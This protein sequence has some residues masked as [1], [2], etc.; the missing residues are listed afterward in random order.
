VRRRVDGDAQAGGCTGRRP[1]ARPLQGCL[2][3]PAGWRSVLPGLGRLAGRPRRLLLV[4]LGGLAAMAGVAML[5]SGRPCRPLQAWAGRPPSAS[6]AS[7]RL[8][9]GGAWGAWCSSR[10]RGGTAGGVG[11]PDGDSCGGGGCWHPPCSQ[12]GGGRRAIGRKPSPVSVD[13]MAAF[14]ERCSPC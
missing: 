14:L 1:G 6:G 8:L 10:R 13:M 12:A 2:L 7:W 3:R 9:G 4:C 5:G 11:L